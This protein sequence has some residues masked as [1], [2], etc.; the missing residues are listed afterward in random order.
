SLR[1]LCKLPPPPPPDGGPPPPLR[2]RGTPTAQSGALSRLRGR[3]TMRSMVEGAAIRTLR[4]WGEVR[5]S[6]HRTMTESPQTTF[7]LTPDAAL[8]FL[9]DHARSLTASDTRVALGLAGG[10]GTGKSTLAA[11]LVAALNAASPEFAALVPMD[12]FHMRQ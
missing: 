8:A 11:E 3:G 1:L 7:A 4:L 10:P 6:Y 2:G 9:A 5:Q 12:G